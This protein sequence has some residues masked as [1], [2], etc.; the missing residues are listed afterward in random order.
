MTK[1]YWILFYLYLICGI[2][3]IISFVLLI[4]FRKKF[5]SQ[6]GPRIASLCIGLILLVVIIVLCT[7]G[8]YLCCKDYNYAK[9][10]TYIEIEGIV[11]DFEYK[12]IDYDGNG[13]MHY[14]NPIIQ[15][16]NIDEFVTLHLNKVEM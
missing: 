11:V 12:K 9:N 1:N 5:V 16:I 3:C 6:K 2:V 8:F 14:S 7:R 4:I 13:K 15:I 10:D